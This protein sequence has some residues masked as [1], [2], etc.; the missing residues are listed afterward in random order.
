MA[1]VASHS[2]FRFVFTGGKIHGR[3]VN[4]MACKQ[5]CHDSGRKTHAGQKHVGRP[6]WD[7]AL[8][9]AMDPPSLL[10]H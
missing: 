2:E 5:E 9:L 8:I 1:S 7:F 4:L 6:P 3:K 10:R